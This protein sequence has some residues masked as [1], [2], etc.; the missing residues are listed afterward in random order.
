MKLTADYHCKC[1]FG[2]NHLHDS[3]WLFSLMK[4][5]LVAKGKPLSNLECKRGSCPDSQYSWHNENKIT[6]LI[7]LLIVTVDT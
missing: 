7:L 1:N 2:L 6:I 5:T 3:A 4:A